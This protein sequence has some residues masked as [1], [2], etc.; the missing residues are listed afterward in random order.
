[1]RVRNAIVAAA[2]MMMTTAPTAAQ[3]PADDMK[4]MLASN[5]FVK[6]EKDASKRQVAVLASYYYLGR[7]DARMSGAQL[8][9]AMK[10]Q[11]PSITPQT[12][13]PIMTACAK[14]LQSAGMAIQTIGSQLGK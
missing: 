2:A 13:G 10:A 1:M 6:A 12:A 4:C 9:A 14:R 3:A 5:L 11:A 7:V 8:S